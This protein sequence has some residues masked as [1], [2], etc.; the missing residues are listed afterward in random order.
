MIVKSWMAGNN[1]REPIGMRA[2]QP[3]CID[4]APFVISADPNAKKDNSYQGY[5]T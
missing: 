3:V 2:I 5:Q 1:D 4:Y